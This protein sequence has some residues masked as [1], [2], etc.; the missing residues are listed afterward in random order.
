ML[1]NDDFSWGSCW[2]GVELF[3]SICGSCFSFCV[4]DFRSSLKAAS[5]SGGIL[6]LRMVPSPSEVT[7][8]GV[9]GKIFDFAVVIYDEVVD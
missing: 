3:E 6:T 8:G 2:V 4:I 5:L 7:I 1:F 9:G